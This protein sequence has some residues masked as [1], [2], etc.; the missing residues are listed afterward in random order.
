MY[1]AAGVQFGPGQ[2]ITINNRDPSTPSQSYRIPDARLGNLT[3]DWSIS[4]KTLADPQ[5]RGFFGA[6]SKPDAVVIIRPSELGPN[7]T[8]IITRPARL[9]PER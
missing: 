5:V 7:G 2:T 4:R 3:I 6:D 9:R 8:Y 1:R